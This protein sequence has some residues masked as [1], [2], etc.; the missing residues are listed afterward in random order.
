MSK[1][2]FDDYYDKIVRQ[3]E[4]LT[5]ALEEVSQEVNDN[6][7]SP[8]VVEKM[9]ATVKP[10]AESYQILSYIKYLIDKPNKQKK[11][12]SKATKTDKLVARNN[13]ILN[14]LSRKEY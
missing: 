12:Y 6:I 13:A 5:H 10:I 1:R 9:K 11:R 7:T 8:E 4:E 3:Y 14:K 2:H